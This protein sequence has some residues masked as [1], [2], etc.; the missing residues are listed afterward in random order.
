MQGIDQIVKQNNETLAIRLAQSTGKPQYVVHGDD[1]KLEVT[2]VDPGPGKAV[3]I[4]RPDF[5]AEV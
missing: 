5:P 2:D 4:G 3:Y 1:G